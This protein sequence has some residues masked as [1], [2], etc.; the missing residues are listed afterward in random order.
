MGH[1][2]PDLIGRQGGLARRR[3]S[4]IVRAF[5]ISSGSL[6]GHV[7]IMRCRPAS[8]RLFM[9]TNPLRE[10]CRKFFATFRIA[11]LVKRAKCH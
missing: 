6:H 7:G 2:I 3:Q 4:L 8:A 1:W 9:L 10:C 5:L 11:V